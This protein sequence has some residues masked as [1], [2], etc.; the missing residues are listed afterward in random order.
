MN[1]LLMQRIDELLT[2]SGDRAGLDCERALR[3]GAATLHRGAPSGITATIVVC[4]V[5][6]PDFA[7]FE[8]L[9]T[10]VADDYGLAAGIQAQPAGYSVRLTCA[11]G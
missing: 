6:R 4:D 2:G 1:H 5:A 7:A 3:V 10:E 8:S 9:V 11:R